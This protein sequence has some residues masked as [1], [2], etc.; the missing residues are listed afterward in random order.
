MDCDCSRPYRH[1]GGEGNYEHII[2][3][4][5]YRGRGSTIEYI[6]FFSDIGKT[7]VRFRPGVLVQEKRDPDLTMTLPTLLGHVLP[8]RRQVPDAVIV[9]FGLHQCSDQW[10]EEALATLANSSSQIGSLMI[11][12]TTTFRSGDLPASQNCDLPALQAFEKF[13][14]SKWQIFNAHNITTE[15]WSSRHTDTNKIM[16]DDNHY[17]LIAYCILNLHLLLQIAEVWNR[18]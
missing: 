14:P 18:S 12:K 15:L 13:A 10:S 16:W 11:W 2:E 6:Q 8:M 5:V 4:R 3:N 1:P 7:S 9:N 17:D